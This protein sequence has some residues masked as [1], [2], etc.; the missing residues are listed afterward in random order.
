MWA[1]VGVTEAAYWGSHLTGVNRLA[2]VSVKLEWGGVKL[3]QSLG[4]FLSLT[5][6]KT[7]FMPF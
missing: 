1:L 6:C 3:E 4:S 5:V 7:E 2:L